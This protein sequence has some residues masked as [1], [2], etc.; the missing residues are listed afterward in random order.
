MTAPAPRRCARLRAVSDVTIHRATPDD[1]FLVAGL[2]L[3]MDRERG[4]A[5]RAGF[6][7][8]Y[9]D[10][11]LAGVDRRPT[12]WAREP[13]GNPVGLLQTTQHDKLPSLLRAT[14]SWLHVN[15]LYVRPTH[16]RRG[17]AE[18][19]LREMLSWGASAGVDRFQLNAEPA[20]RSLYERV[21]FCAPQRL[22]ELRVERG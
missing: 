7:T 1:A 2:V 14:T 18:A 15:L 8:E 16:R 22:M 20:A 5:P 12:W 21:G 4:A 9:A 6:L 17:I 19:L 11:W 3:A 13:D 10:A